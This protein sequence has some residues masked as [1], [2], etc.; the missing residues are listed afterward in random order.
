M[1]TKATSFCRTVATKRASFDPTVVEPANA[2]FLLYRPYYSSRIL[3]I[4]RCFRCWIYLTKARIPIYD[5]FP[6]LSS[7]HSKPRIT[8]G[9]TFLKRCNPA[10]PDRCA[11]LYRRTLPALIKILPDT[12]TGDI[13][14]TGNWLLGDSK[15]GM[16]NDAINSCVENNS[17]VPPR[18]NQAPSEYVIMPHAMAG[19]GRLGHFRL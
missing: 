10:F 16:W 19:T 6:L 18:S 7:Y 17:A 15:I 13:L 12:C 8:V 9:M 11:Q 5:R 2:Y 3:V 14:W 1:A 4:G